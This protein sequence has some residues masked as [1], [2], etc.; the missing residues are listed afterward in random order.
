MHDRILSMW[1]AV[2]FLVIICVVFS[3]YL[4]EKNKNEKLYEMLEDIHTQ[5]QEEL[6]RNQHLLNKINDISSKEKEGK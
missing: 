5:Y 3:F 4:A 2:I 6:E 1:F